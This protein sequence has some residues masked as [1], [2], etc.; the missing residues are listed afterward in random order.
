MLTIEVPGERRSLLRRLVRPRIVAVF[1]FR[2]DAHLVRDL[3]ANITPI[4][5]GWISWDDR[6]ATEPFTGDPGRRR[7]LL[8]AAH[9]AGAQ[10]VL[11]V[12][13]DERFEHAVANRIRKM[14][15]IPGKVCWTF[16]LREMYSPVSYRVDGIWGTKLQKRLFPIFN[17]QFPITDKSGFSSAALHGSWVPPHYRQLDSHLNLY[18]LKMIEPKRRV[19]RRDLYNAL[20]PGRRYQK[21][22]YDYLADESGA[23]FETLPPGRHYLPPHKEDHGLWMGAAG[24]LGSGSGN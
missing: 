21:V 22:G 6:A 19:A 12:D 9:A 15:L 20:D 2:Y 3:I 7:T 18:H 11:A 23:V 8:S 17:D 16:N 10:W 13:P 5:D 14:V 24:T 1:S 4:V